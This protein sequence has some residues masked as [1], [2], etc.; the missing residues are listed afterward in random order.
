MSSVSNRL[1]IGLA[2]VWVG[3]SAMSVNGQ[4]AGG[5]ADGKA[6]KNPVAATPESIAAGQKV[7][8]KYCK[9]CHGA[10]AKGNGP[11]A[12]EGTHPPDLTDDKWDH[13]SSDGEIFVAIRDGI[14][15]KFD[16]KGF[17]SKLT[18]PEMWQ[19]VTYLRSLGSKGAAPRP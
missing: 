16:M 3:M 18:A 10:D 5:H 2:I 17:K 9:F 6:M 8:Q 14:G 4:P 7:Y 19:V 1:V 15:P 13:G 11:M 12:P